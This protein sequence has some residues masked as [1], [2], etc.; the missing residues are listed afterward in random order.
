MDNGE[1]VIK[2]NDCHWIDNDESNTDDLCLHGKVT[3]CIENSTVITSYDCTVSVAAL[4]LMRTIDSDHITNN[5]S[6]KQLLPCCG[7]FMI[8]DEKLQNVEIPGCPNGKDWSVKHSDCHVAIS[9]A[10]EK[11]TVIPLEVYKDTIFKFANK[12][13]QF[14]KKSVPRSIPADEIEHNGYTAFWNEWKWRRNQR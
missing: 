5:N 3:I 8:A 10:A 9:F 1:F 2:L 13:E 12:V 6:D 7:H 4:Y 14:Y 11:E